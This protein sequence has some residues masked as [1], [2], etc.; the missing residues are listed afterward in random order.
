MLAPPGGGGQIGVCGIAGYVGQGD[1]ETLRRMI[2]AIK[3]RGPDDRGVFVRGDTG[4]AHARLSIIDLSEQGH[5]PMF[6][7]DKTVAIVFNGEIYN[8]Q[9]LKKDLLKLG[10]YNFRS[11]TDTEVIIYLYQEYGERCF[12]KLNG[13]FAIAIYDAR[14]N[15][16]VL[17][18]DRM[19]K[20]PLY[21]GIFNSTF[22]FGS[23]LK[24]LMQHPEFRKE[25]NLESLNKYLQYEY[26]PTPNSIFKNIYKL[27]PASY[28][29]YEN[30]KIRKEKFWEM[31]FK[32]RMNDS[33]LLSSLD[34]MLEKS[35][36][37]RL[38]SDVPLGIFL[39]G[40]LDS[41]T[42]AYYAQK[43]SNSKI[44]TFFIGFEEKSFDESDYAN[45]VSQ[46][47]GTEHYS[48]ILTQKDSL[49]IMPYTLENIDE[50]LADASIIPTYLLAKFTREKVTVALSGDGGD[51][52]FAGY[53]TFQAD[54]LADIYR[55]VPEFI[56]KNLLEKFIQ[57]LP[58]S[59]KNFSLDFKL[60]KFI[61]GAT[62]AR[63]HRHQVWL[64]SFNREERRKLF[65]REVWQDLERKNEFEETDRYLSEIPSI[66]Y[67]YLR[68][69]LM[70]NILV[71]ADRASMLNSLEVRSPLLDYQVV[72]FVNSL[73]YDFKIRGWT[74]KY[75][76][77][78][79]M[80]DKLP[81][82]IVSR[83]KKGFG[84]PL[85]YWLRHDLKSFC[86]E[87][88]SEQN[89]GNV[90]LFN[91]EYVSKLKQEHF[92]LKR[93]NRKLLWTLMIFQIWHNKWA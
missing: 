6:S 11:K 28:L 26:V 17:A 91:F 18:R 24:A 69:Y 58:I 34:T 10:K 59:D 90:G 40:G 33:R 63:P 61:E 29:V 43:N 62:L 84:I 3:Y 82:D 71:K 80:A 48:Q 70:D 27:E 45:K 54:V 74:G 49:G 51:E 42:I 31:S 72:D 14:Y 4:L 19:G 67:L 83:P 64:G 32:S 56:R 92:S 46:F 73:P 50:P 9:E 76:L 15:K 1:Q 44:K 16:L 39:S 86:N 77:K 8:F 75:I 88:L 22:I 21:W 7:E 41:S 12:E 55:K 79:L 65:K 87:V 78:K 93:N 30:N 52:L 25:L 23:E 68:T 2:A 36:K 57:D 38:S 5:Q 37:A 66:L 35:V 47:L 60:K 13:M 81:K 20:K 89:I 85:S 53:P